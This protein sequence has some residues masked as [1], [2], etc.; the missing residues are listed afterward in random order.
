[1]FMRESL[2]KSAQVGVPILAFKTLSSD[3]RFNERKSR[4][5]GRNV[6]AIRHSQK[7]AV[8]QVPRRA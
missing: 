6:V 5:N 2:T 1:M 3:V 8:L 4:V 7:T